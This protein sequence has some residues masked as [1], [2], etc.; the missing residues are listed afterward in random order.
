MKETLLIAN[1]PVMWILALIIIANVIVQ[2]FIFYR[3][4]NKHVKET[5][6]ISS[7]QVKEAFKIGFIGTIGQAFAV[8]AVTVALN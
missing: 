5:S 6:L 7:K 2:S 4:A 1:N 3:L 8:F